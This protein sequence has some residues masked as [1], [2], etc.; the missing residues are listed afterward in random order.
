[1]LSLRLIIRT[2]AAPSVIQMSMV[3]S[4]FSSLRSFYPSDF[5]DFCIPRCAS[6]GGRHRYSHSRHYRSYKFQNTSTKKR[7]IG[8]QSTNTNYCRWISEKWNYLRVG[9]L[10][11][12]W[13]TNSALLLLW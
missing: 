2:D 8:T 4:R 9:F 7:N 11:V 13:I 5:V 12:F 1:V 10:L 6:F 3:C